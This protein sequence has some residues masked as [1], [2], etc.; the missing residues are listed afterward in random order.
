MEANLTAYLIFMG[1]G[2]AACVLWFF[3][4]RG[5]K[6]GFGK[7]AGLSALV[8]VLGAVLGLVCARLGWILL[9]INV[10]QA[11]DF[12]TL[13]HDELSYYGGMA[14]VILAVWLSA[15][16]MRQPAREVL[17]DFA[18]MGALMAAV[19]RFAEY[20]LGMLGL[21]YVEEWAEAEGTLFLPA[22]V[23][24]SYDE[25]FFEFYLAV[26]VFSGLFSLVAMLESIA[27]GKEKYRFVRTLF[28]LCL[29]QILLECMRTQKISWL[30]VPAEQLVCYLLCEGVLVWAAVRGRKAG[31]RAWVPA[32]VG[33]LACG[34][35]IA[36]EFALD[37]KI[38]LGDEEYI[39]QWVT[40]GVMALSLAA[41][42]VGEHFAL[43]RIQAEA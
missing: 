3:I 20:F 33:L 37:G 1:C 2:A 9:R 41:M 32:L 11:K 18:P 29:P 40:Y 26:F 10:F 31:F 8:L 16:L 5:R 12:L 15:K 39:P 35:I 28:Y 24:I 38:M 6:A 42:A 21:G 13:R 14:G 25:E 30:F 27:H 22:A 34:V 17:N 23:R 4:A 36:G 43:R 7:S 19:A